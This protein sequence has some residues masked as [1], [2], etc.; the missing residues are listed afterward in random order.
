MAEP[1]PG[2]FGSPA[3]PV[4]VRWDRIVVFR[5]GGRWDQIVVITLERSLGSDHRNDTSAVAGIR[6]S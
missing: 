6:S 2:H 1:D 3:R 5:R 4:G